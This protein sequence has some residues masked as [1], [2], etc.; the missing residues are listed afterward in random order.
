MIENVVENIGIKKVYRD[1]FNNTAISF[2]TYSLCYLTT[3]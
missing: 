3:Y 2:M 1:M